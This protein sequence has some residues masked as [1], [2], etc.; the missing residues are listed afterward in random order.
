MTRL[1]IVHF[2]SEADRIIHGIERQENHVTK[3]G[4]MDRK[5][6]LL[7]VGILLVFGTYIALSIRL[8]PEKV[9]EAKMNSISFLSTETKI[10][11]IV[12][13]KPHENRKDVDVSIFIEA[14]P[15]NLSEQVYSKEGVLE[16][17]NISNNEEFVIENFRLEGLNGAQKALSLKRNS[18]KMKF[19]ENEITRTGL[20]LKGDLS[21]AMAGE[22]S[23]L[24]R[25]TWKN[26]MSYIGGE[27]YGFLIQ[28]AKP[29]K[30]GN[31]FFRINNLPQV[32]ERYRILLSLPANMETVP[33]HPFPSEYRTS[34]EVFFDIGSDNLASYIKFSEISSKASKELFMM[35]FA[36][37]MGIGIGL[38]VDFFKE[39]KKQSD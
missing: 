19:G 16:L 24:I 21:R 31:E 13:I 11:P 3:G 4:N 36:A 34:K 32:L 22:N 14:T 9:S 28:M 23:A 29:D 18:I 39:S 35:F 25:F 8:E 26:F 20:E 5:Y 15:D 10:I 17:V 38:I 2:V 27:R 7:I 6:V 37:V 30:L 12:K 33:E 1:Q